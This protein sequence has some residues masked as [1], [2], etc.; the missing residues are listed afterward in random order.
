MTID[1]PGQYFAPIE[2]THSGIHHEEEGHGSFLKSS[3]PRFDTF[4]TS[5][6]LTE[7]SDGDVQTGQSAGKGR[8]RC[9]LYAILLGIAVAIAA[10]TVVATSQ[11]S[12]A[13]AGAAWG[14]SASW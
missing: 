12:P 11:S 6:E 13:L 7:S 3:L 14:P 4:I 8:R 10:I 1:A 2:V 9:L 5:E